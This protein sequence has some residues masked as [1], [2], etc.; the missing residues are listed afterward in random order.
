MDS[1]S[2]GKKSSGKHVT[3]MELKYQGRKTSRA[4]SEQRRRTILEAALRIVVRDGVRGVRHRA[5]AKEA[6]V[7]LSAT[8]YYFKDITDLITDTFT[9]F[10]EMGAQKFKAYWEESDSML[11]MAMKELEPSDRTSRQVFADRISNLAIEYVLIQLK[12]HR[13]YLIAERAF[14]QECLRNENL[15]PI[16]FSHQKF[17]LDSLETFFSRIGSNHP[18]IDA[19]LFASI[20]LHVEYQGLVAGFE[21]ERTA[22]RLRIMLKRQIELMLGIYN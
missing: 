3:G 4:N 1:S 16:A 19:E 10:V 5:V 21:D 17:F 2:E 8:T 20:I 12:E 11:K 13:D 14:Q 7:P 15:R 22:G 18:D 9:L 6:N